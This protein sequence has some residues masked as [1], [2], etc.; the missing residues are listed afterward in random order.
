MMQLT[1]LLSDQPFNFLQKANFFLK[2]KPS[3][4]E[5]KQIFPKFLNIGKKITGKNIEIIKT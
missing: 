4:T 3:A 2:N 5:V 1:Y